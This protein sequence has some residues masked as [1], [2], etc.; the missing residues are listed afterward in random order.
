[1]FLLVTQQKTIKNYQKFLVKNLKDQFSRI[2]IKQKVIIKIQQTNL[3]FFLNQIF[4]ES[5]DYF[6]RLRKSRCCFNKRFKA[7][8]NDLPKGVIDNYNVTVNEKHFYDQ[9]IDSD[10]K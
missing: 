10:I 5:M 7:K 6:F 8:N 9:P 2:K 4:Q 1:M 3:D